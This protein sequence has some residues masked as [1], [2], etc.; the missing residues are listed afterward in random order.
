MDDG[1]TGTT[2]IRCAGCSFTTTSGSA[3]VNHKAD[4]G[5]LVAH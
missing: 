4:T 5:H 1:S 2:T 3:W